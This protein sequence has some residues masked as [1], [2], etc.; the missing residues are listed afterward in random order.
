MKDGE[1]VVTKTGERAV[2]PSKFFPD[3]TPVIVVSR[4][5]FAKFLDRVVYGE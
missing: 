4:D 3:G 2:F 1:I 5:D